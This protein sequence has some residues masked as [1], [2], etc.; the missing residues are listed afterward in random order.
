MEP[1][2]S[3]IT[4]QFSDAVP[5]IL[6]GVAQT[7]H[8]YAEV[9]NRSFGRSY[10]IGP[11]C[12]SRTDDPEFY[13]RYS[14]IPIPGSHP[15]RIGLAHLDASFLS[16]LRK[17]PFSLVHSHTPFIAGDIALRV[18]RMRKIPLVSTFHT[19][20]HEDLAKH[21]SSRIIIDSVLDHI[22]SYYDTCDAV[23]VPS[24]R[25]VDVLRTYGYQGK[26]IHIPN[27]TDMRIPTPEQ[28]RTLKDE[29]YSSFVIRKDICTLLFVGQHRWEKNPRLILESLKRLKNK[30]ITFQ[31]LFAGSGPDKKAIISLAESLKLTP[32]VRFLGEIQDRRIL[33][34]LYA[35]S[36]LLV[37]P[38]LYDTASLTMREAAAFSI[39]SVVVS[40]SVTADL[41]EDGI[42]G[43]LAENTSEA[44]TAKL[45]EIIRNP[46]K[47]EAA[48]RGARESIYIHWEDVVKKLF[49]VYK[50]LTAGSPGDNPGTEAARRP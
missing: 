20:Y 47:R 48:G 23:L 16:T 33:Q 4:G 8:H 18:S 11:K 3:L 14:S 9:L 37:F 5:P 49:Q 38:S 39:P 27:G 30:K 2:T 36:D 17:I 40:G 35:V 43:F 28:L 42:N 21:F 1:H 7:A 46:D 13:I 6:D 22:A 12:P 10:L 32:E 41:I 24:T 25:A 19:Q 15:Y 34:S 26:T 29:G 44:F 50:N 45:E 31:M